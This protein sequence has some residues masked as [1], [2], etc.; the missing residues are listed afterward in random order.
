MSI[1]EKIS[2]LLTERVSPSEIKKF[3]GALKKKNIKK[4]SAKTF[5]QVEKATGKKS[6]W[7]IDNWTAIKAAVEKSGIVVENE[8]ISE[9]VKKFGFDL[10][11]GESI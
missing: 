11:D 5:P 10:T 2:K 7:I 1:K 8:E 4:I 9:A 3:V 6:E